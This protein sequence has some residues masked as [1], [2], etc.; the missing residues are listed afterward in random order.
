[1]GRGKRKRW[2]NGRGGG[3]RGE[4]KRIRDDSTGYEPIV[5]KSEAFEK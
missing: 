2:G 3:Q 4:Q 5:L 1:M